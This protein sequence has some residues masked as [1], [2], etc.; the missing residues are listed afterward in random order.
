MR[1]LYETP[2]LEVVTFKLSDVLSPSKPLPPTE[3]GA[4]GGQFDNTDPWDVDEP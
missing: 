1:K 3:V 4:G 2:E